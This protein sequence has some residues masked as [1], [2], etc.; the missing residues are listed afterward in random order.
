M[1]ITELLKNATNGILTEDTLNEIEKA[2]NQSVTDKVKIHVEKALNEQDEDYSNKLKH[3]LDVIDKDHTN[4]LVK[5][6]EAIDENH[7]KKLKQIVEKYRG[8]LNLGAKDFKDNLINNVSTY[9]EAYID[10]AIPAEKINEAVKSKKAAIVLEQIKEI[11]G[12]DSAVAKQS[13]RTAIIDGKRQIDEAVQKLEVAQKE[14]RQLREENSRIKSELVLEKKISTVEGKK[15]EYL[16]RILKGK[17][18]EFITENFDYASNLFDRSETDRLQNI[19]EEAHQ[20]SVLT[21]VDRP[22]IE[23]QTQQTEESNFDANGYMSPYLKELNK[24]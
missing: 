1:S 20:A 13:V 6:V 4:K 5:V 11:L 10:E 18:A 2:F 17:T 8:E 14:A 24:F 15:K 3:L 16:N 21:S 19:K 22:V 7:S 23:E 12:V 9:L